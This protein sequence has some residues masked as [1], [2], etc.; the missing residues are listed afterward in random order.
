[1]SVHTT[2]GCTGETVD[3][4]FPHEEAVGLRYYW[5]QDHLEEL[6]R[7]MTDRELEG[8]TIVIS[9]IHSYLD[10]LHF[11]EKRVIN[12]RAFVKTMEEVFEICTAEVIARDVPTEED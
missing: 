8:A 10:R 12:R 7:D 5:L 4:V 6:I 11:E 1:M 3:E 9:A 2:G